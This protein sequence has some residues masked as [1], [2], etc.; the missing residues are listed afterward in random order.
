MSKLRK[1]AAVSALAIAAATP[2]MAEKLGLGRPALPEEIAA[3]DVAVLPDGAGLPEGSGDVLTGE[4]VFAEKCASC[5]GDFAEGIDNWPVLAGG[6]GT[7]TNVRPVKTVGSYWPYLST[8]WDYVHRSMPFGG[9]QTV[10]VDE[11]YAITA[12]I[13]YSNG[14]VEDDFVLSRENFTEIAL[15]NAEGFY[16]DDRAETEY[17]AFSGAPCMTDCMAPVKV[18]K[19]A[20]DLNVTPVDPDGKPAGTLPDLHMAQATAE[21]AATAEPSVE[22]E[23]ENAAAD[24]ALVEAGEGV[25]KKCKACHKI[26]EGAKNGTGPL[27]NGIVGRAAATVD[28]FRYSKPMADAGAGGLVWNDET[29]ATFLE[30]P[31]KYV[32]KTKMSFAGLKKEEERAAVIAYLK[33]FAE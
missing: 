22:A 30:D 29:L 15:P 18:T 2:V 20:V 8:V 1:I 3:W 6:Q 11:V 13:L 23:A 17:G 31:R 25:F 28:G 21:P 33:S 14:I 4:E 32:P 26:G 7:L 5:H 9:A 16:P 19:R 12:F 24:P 27:L 10:S